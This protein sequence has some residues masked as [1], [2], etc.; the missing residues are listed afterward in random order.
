MQ[1][2][3]PCHNTTPSFGAETEEVFAAAPQRTTRDRDHHKFIP[4]VRLLDTHLLVTLR[5]LTQLTQTH[6]TRIWELNHVLLLFLSVLLVAHLH[7]L[8][9]RITIV[10]ILC[11]HSSAFARTNAGPNLP[12]HPRQESLVRTAGP[13]TSTPFIRNIIT[14]ILAIN[15]SGPPCYSAF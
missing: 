11:G 1:I 15:N 8:T 10:V 9:A 3:R 2:P 5:V 6:S 4:L 12:L 7:S 13:Q 14:F